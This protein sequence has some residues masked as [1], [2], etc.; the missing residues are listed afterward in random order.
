MKFREK[1]VIASDTFDRRNETESWVNAIF[2]NITK[3][4][5]CTNRTKKLRWCWEMNVCMLRGVGEDV[6]QCVCIVSRAD[7]GHGAKIRMNSNCITSSSALKAA[8]H[9]VYTSEPKFN[10]SQHVRDCEIVLRRDIWNKENLRLGFEWDSNE[11]FDRESDKWQNW[12]VYY[13]AKDFLDGIHE[14]WLIRVIHRGWSS[15]WVIKMF[16]WP[17]PT[18]DPSKERENFRPHSRLWIQ[19]TL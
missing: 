14:S 11:N 2:R 15:Q 3:T 19:K 6:F 4:E 8:D 18:G 1:L 5:N 7:Y 12:V 16:Q 10:A 9:M 13:R 17:E